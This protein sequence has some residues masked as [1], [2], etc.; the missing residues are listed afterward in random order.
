L[1]KI[2]FH[3]IFSFSILVLLSYIPS[4]NAEI[5][6]GANVLDVFFPGPGTAELQT[7]DCSPGLKAIGAGWQS[8][9]PEFTRLIDAK[10]FD[11]TSWK[12]KFFTGEPGGD[13]VRIHTVCVEDVDVQ[14][15]SKEVTINTS[16]LSHESPPQCPSGFKIVGAGW[17]ALDKDKTQLLESIP[18]DQTTWSLGFLHDGTGD[19]VTI[20]SVCVRPIALQVVSQNFNI[21]TVQDNIGLEMPQCPSGF[22]IVGAGWE[23]HD[24]DQTLMLESRPIPPS[25][26][27]LEYRFKNP[28]G[29]SFTAH[30]ICIDMSMPVGGEMIPL[31]TTSLLLGYTILNSYWIAPTAVGIGV[32]I[33]LVKRKIE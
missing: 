14:N 23:D 8:L 30:S 6:A 20:H 29:D 7:K 28:G 9:N 5:N 32:G 17:E 12:L 24:P 11:E 1:N 4:V 19:T 16:G 3:A 21:D 22:K 31:E 15:L 25:G 26:W 33:Y 18:V 2:P 27:S 10:P 13:G